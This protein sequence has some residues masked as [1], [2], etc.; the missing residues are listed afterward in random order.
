MGLMSGTSLDGLDIA[1]CSFHRE[2]QRWKYEL[3]YSKT[4]SYNK[5]WKESLAGASHLDSD[6]L[7]ELDRK[8]GNYLGSLINSSMKDAEIEPELIASHGHTV[9]HNPDMGYSLQ[10]GHGANIAGVTGKNVVTDFRSGDIALGGQGA[11]LVPAG[12]KLLFSEYQS[13]LNLGG[14]S[15]ISFDFKNE[16]I[17][18][19]ICPVNIVLNKIAFKMGSEYDNG[20]SLGRKGKPI[21]KLEQKL[22]SLAYYD[23]SPP[24]SLSKEWLDKYFL[25]LFEEESSV[26]EDQMNTMYRHIAF[27]IASTIDKYNLKDVLITGGGAHNNFLMELLKTNT[28][29]NLILPEKTIIDYKEA[30]VFAFLGLLRSLDIVNCYASVTGAL[31]NSIV[32]TVYHG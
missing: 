5:H 22:N 27:Q 1:M 3:I 18:F 14:F 32:G 30:I 26:L 16:R 24:K 13:C 28:T 6:K 11:P 9:F 25:P 31:N 29:A 15:N 19:D 8:Y 4:Y 20:G 10:I 17:A 2:N 7:A 21:M 23:L 12:D